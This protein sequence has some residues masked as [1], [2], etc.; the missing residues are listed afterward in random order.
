MTCAPCWGARRRREIE[1]LVADLA[2]PDGVDAVLE[3]AAGRDIGL[4]VSNAGFG[5]KGA[6]QAQDRARLDAMLNVNARAPL[7]L[8]HALLPRMLARAGAG[9]ILTGSV[10]GE[11]PFPWSSAY[12][13]TK[14][15]VH[16]FGMSLHGELAGSGVDVLGAGTGGDRH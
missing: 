14:A 11:A 4:L 12:A 1:P 16:S 2:A 10:E 7:L 5:L 9:I 3:G 6:F 8:I 15:F 13:A